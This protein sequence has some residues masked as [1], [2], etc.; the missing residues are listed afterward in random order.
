MSNPMEGCTEAWGYKTEEL[1]VHLCRHV[2]SISFYLPSLNVER[3]I[4][5]KVYHC[6]ISGTRCSRVSNHNPKKLPEGG[7]VIV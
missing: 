2:Y 3:N 7:A 4:N 1:N 6:K 5:E